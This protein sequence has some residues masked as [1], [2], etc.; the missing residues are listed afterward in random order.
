LTIKDRLQELGIELPEVAKPVAAYVPAILIDSYVY[1]AGQIPL[2]KGE[3]KY[4]GRLGEDLTVEEGYEAARI[5]A[6]N[7]LAAIKSVIGDLN[8]VERIIKVNGFVQSAEGFYDQAKVL[9]GAS[10]LLGKI[11]GESGKHSRSA[12]GTNTLPLNAPVEVEIIA[13]IK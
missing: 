4:R 11:F 13:K 8:K 2:V 10:E 6:L 1:T 3:L 5:C 9:N 7:A 12:I